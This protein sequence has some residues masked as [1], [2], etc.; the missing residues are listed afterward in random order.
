MRLFA[1]INL[2]AAVIDGLREEQKRLAEFEQH[3]HFV[4]DSGLHMTLCFVGEVHQQD[5][6]VIGNGIR[7][8]L[9]GEA[10]FMLALGD[11]GSFPGSDNA[12]VVWVG[13]DGELRRLSNI[14][15]VIADEIR[16]LG[17]RLDRRPFS[18]HVTLA[19]VSRNASEDERRSIGRLAGDLTCYR[20]GSFEVRSVELMESVLSREG[21][22]YSTVAQ[23][24]LV[25]QG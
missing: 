14:Q 8:A 19:R 15:N 17:Y 2:P 23:I 9:T 13:V 20:L 16:S 22:T 25:N 3:L 18:P 1:A 7:S 10:P 4:D 6:E 24:S 12:R 21:A 5:V 11:G